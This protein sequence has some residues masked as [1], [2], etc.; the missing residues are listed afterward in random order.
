MESNKDEVIEIL[1][2]KT[3]S[4]LLDRGVNPAW[5][6]EGQ[7]TKEATRC[8]ASVKRR[9]RGR[10]S[11]RIYR[12]YTWLAKHFSVQVISKKHLYFLG[13]QKQSSKTTSFSS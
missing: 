11:T 5:P 4:A 6:Q 3:I 13:M 9:H 7:G 8:G 2:S 1:D 10:A 12:K